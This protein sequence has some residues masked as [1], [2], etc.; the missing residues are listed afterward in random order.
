MGIAA[1]EPIAPPAG[2]GTVGKAARLAGEVLLWIASLTGAACIILAILGAFFGFRVMLFSSGSMEPGIPVGSAALVRITDAKDLSIGDV[3]TVER[4]AGKLPVTH[5]IVGV[6][7]AP[8]PQQ[9]E[10]VLKGDAN[11]LA[12]P[13]PYTVAEAGKL[14]FSVPGIAGAV[15]SLGTPQALAPLGAVAAGFVVWGLWP[16]RVRKEAG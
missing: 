15:S 2:G 5:R 11:E 3:V 16:R 13:A 9:R 12:D 10:L 1:M 4:G 7:A 6:G 14:L 8:D